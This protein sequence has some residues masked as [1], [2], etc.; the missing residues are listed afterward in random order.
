MYCSIAYFENKRRRL[1]EIKRGS[2]I[3]VHR[4]SC[5]CERVRFRLKAPK[6]LKAVGVRSKLNFPRLIIPCENFEPLTDEDLFSLYTVRCEKSVGVH[7]FC[8]FCGMH[9]VFSETTEPVEIHINVD[10]LDRST[11]QEINMVSFEMKE[12][13]PTTSAASFNRRGIGSNSTPFLAS[14]STLMQFPSGPHAYAYTEVEEPIILD[15]TI[16]ASNGSSPPYAPAA[17]FTSFDGQNMIEPTQSH[18]AS[19]LFDDFSITG[20][21]THPIFVLCSSRFV[22]LFL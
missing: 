15:T 5:H 6:F 13:Y 9:V 4:G 12:T 3:V 8:S 20:G 22:T 18:P 17:V 11:V 2:E 1:E 16:G 10:C 14:L 7:A 21:L 19:T